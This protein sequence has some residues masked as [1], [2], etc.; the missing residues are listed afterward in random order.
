[1]IQEF[2]TLEITTTGQKLYKFTNKTIEWINKLKIPSL[3]L[4]FNGLVILF[5]EKYKVVPLFLPAIIL[6]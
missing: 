4:S 5:S 6:I 1:M 3:T 2:Y